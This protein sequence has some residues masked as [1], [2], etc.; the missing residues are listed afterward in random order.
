[1]KTNSLSMEEIQAVSLEILKFV[2]DIC[3]ENQ[4]TYSLAY[5][6]L[7][8]AVRHKGFIPWDDD[9]DIWMPRPDY[10]KLEKIFSER[11]EEFLPYKMYNRKVVKKYPYMITRICDDRYVIETENEDSCGMGIF[12]DI[13]VV[14]G[15]GNSREEA[16]KIIKKSSRLSSM[17]FLSTR[18]YF[19]K[20]LTEGKIARLLKYPIYL[21]AKIMGKD[22]WAKRIENIVSMYDWDTCS[23]V[24]CAIWGGRLIYTGIA[25]KDYYCKLI[26]C[27]F[28]QYEFFIPERYDEILT[29]R[30][31]DYMALPPEDKRVYHHLF[32]AYKK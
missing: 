30:Y 19:S 13:Y 31:G 23:Y 2:A 24:G 15:L 8:G 16:D 25:P 10:E 3:D 11:V 5:G 32:K 18:K 27:Q 6:T 4:L 28:G 21:L 22:F 17:M 9:I 26:K 29:K 20:G 7:L 1:M 12:V 14:D